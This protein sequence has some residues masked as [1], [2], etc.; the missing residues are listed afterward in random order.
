M[1]FHLLTSLANISG[2]LSALEWVS[3]FS[4]YLG[5]DL[6]VKG[7]NWGDA[8]ALAVPVLGLISLS[9]VLFQRRDITQMG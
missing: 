6:L 3:P 2:A 9:L 8:V 5:S 1:V 7:M 4:Y